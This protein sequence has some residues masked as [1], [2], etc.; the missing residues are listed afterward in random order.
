MLKSK[1]N[2]IQDSIILSLTESKQ[3]FFSNEQIISWFSNLK[4]FCDMTTQHID[5]KSLSDWSI[6]NE[7]IQH[8]DNKYFEVLGLKIDILNR[9]VQTWDQP[10]IKQLHEGIIGFIIKNINGVYHLLVQ[11]KIESGNYD[12]FEMAPTVQCITGNYK[13]PEYEVPYLEYFLND[14]MDKDTIYDTI[15]SEEGG[16]FYHEQNRNVV[17]VVGEDFPLKVHERYIWMTFRQVKEF[18]KYNNYF[19][20][21]ARSLIACISPV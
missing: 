2:N 16:R 21:E 19:N 13:E 9:E 5:L 20:I 3:S 8:K 10:I 1:Q 4:S 7:K 12:T 18:I 14:K 6:S 17:I 15:Q 11:A